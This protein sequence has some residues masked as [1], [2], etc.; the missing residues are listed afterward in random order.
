MQYDSSVVTYSELLT[1]L[2][3][4]MDPTTKNRQVCSC[5]YMSPI[6]VTF[7]SQ[8]NDFGTQ[9][10]SGI[11]YHT[12]EQ[13]EMAIASRDAEQ[14]K[15]KDAIVTEILPAREWYRAEDYHQQYLEKGAFVAV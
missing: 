14:L 3:D 8:G 7:T 15:H 9:Y 2:W 6:I 11:Y 10:R 4:R 5:W 12:D 13:K 1:V